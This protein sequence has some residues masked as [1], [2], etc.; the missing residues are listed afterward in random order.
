MKNPFPPATEDIPSHVT[1][2]STQPQVK[3]S[4]HRSPKANRHRSV[5]K[6]EVTHKIP[7]IKNDWKS[8]KTFRIFFLRAAGSEEGYGVRSGG[9]ENIK[10]IDP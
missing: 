7:E 10:Y 3:Q 8:L 5:N 4:L 1:R 6:E 2:E 9:I